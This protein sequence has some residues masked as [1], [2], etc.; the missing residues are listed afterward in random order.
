MSFEKFIIDEELCRMV[1]ETLK[2]IKI[3]D[4]SIDINFIKEVGIGGDYLMQA[5]TLELYV[6]LCLLCL[7]RLLRMYLLEGSMVDRPI[8]MRARA[9]L[10]LERTE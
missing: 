3:T 10:E 2:P 5:K 7:V 6:D 8:V 1:M 9:I 4:K